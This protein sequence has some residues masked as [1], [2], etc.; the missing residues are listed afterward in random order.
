MLDRGF[1]IEDYGFGDEP[2]MVWCSKN[3]GVF[4]CVVRGFRRVLVER[5]HVLGAEVRKVGHG[6]R[7]FITGKHHGEWDVAIHHRGGLSTFRMRNE[8]EAR[9]LKKWIDKHGSGR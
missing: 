5:L 7:N 3:D 4:V 1:M 6:N 9:H 8:G 2:R